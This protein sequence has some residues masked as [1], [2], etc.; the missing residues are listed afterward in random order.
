LIGVIL[1]GGTG[2][3]LFPVTVSVNK[4]LLNVYF[5]PLIHYPLMN[6]MS[7]GIKKI[8]IVTN[9]SDIT[10]FDQLLGDGSNFGISITYTSQKFPGGLPHAI[11]SAKRYLV[12]KSA[13]VILGDTYFEPNYFKEIFDNACRQFNNLGAHILL[14]QVRDGHKYGTVT[15]KNNQIIE[16]IE[17]PRNK[18]LLNKYLAM[19]GLYIFDKTLLNF[20]K[21]LTPSNRGEL[22]MVDLLEMYRRKNQ[23]HFTILKKKFK[24]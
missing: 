24:F 16:M 20:I 8:I 3:R 5:Q 9:S 21:E 12:N 2:S 4:H 11:Y 10:A 19:S 18:N 6:L 7:A 23:L 22:E 1:A 13:V 15:L 14:S 17:K